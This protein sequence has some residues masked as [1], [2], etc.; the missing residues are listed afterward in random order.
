MVGFNGG[1]PKAAGQSAVWDM[2]QR[3]LWLRFT[4]LL[5]QEH[6]LGKL[7]TGKSGMAG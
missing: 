7:N 4:S 3:K 2:R 1:D 6:R 5:E